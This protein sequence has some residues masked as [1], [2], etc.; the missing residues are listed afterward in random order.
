MTEPKRLTAD[1]YEEDLRQ[2]YVAARAAAALG[3]IATARRL[4]SAIS[5]H[6]PAFAGLDALE[7]EISRAEP[8]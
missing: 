7:A 4:S 1:P 2:W 5:E 3:D 8:D 6:D